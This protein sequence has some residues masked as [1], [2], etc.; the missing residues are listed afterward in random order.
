MRAGWAKRRRSVEK[1]YLGGACLNVGCI[2]TKTFLRSSKL[3]AECRN[4]AAFGIEIPSA[5]FN[6]QAVVQ[7]KNKVV[8]TLTRG[9]ETLLKQSGVEVIR[10]HAQIASKQ[11]VQVGTETYHAKNILIATGS[12]PSMPP[13]PGIDSEDVLDSTRILD[14]SELPRKIAIIGGGYVGLEFAVF[15][16]AVGVEVVVI[17]MLS[18]NRGR[19]AITT[20]PAGLRRR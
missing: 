2:P 13:I 10:G 11:S 19:E 3:F 14:L 7:R 16:A 5:S 9:V 8:A 15:F 17:E 4:S 20:F 18:P 12:R 6:L 1:E